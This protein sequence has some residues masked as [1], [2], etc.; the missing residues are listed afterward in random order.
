MEPALNIEEPLLREIQ[1]YWNSRIHDQEIATAPVNS[2][3]FFEELDAY[4]YEKL[5]YLP[6]LL[7]FSTYAGKT[8]LE[9]GCGVGTDLVRFAR[10]GAIVTGVDIAEHSINLAG[11]NFELQELTADLRVMNGEALTFETN[12]FDVVY[13]HGV[14]QYTANPSKMVAEIHRVLKPHGQAI[15]MFYNRISWLN[16]VSKVTKVSLE[17]DDAPAFHLVSAREFRQLLAPFTDVRLIPERFPVESRL[18]GGLK[19]KLYN[20]L[21]V[22]AFHVLPKSV[23]RRFGWHLMAFATK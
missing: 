1:E 6:K 9:I 16:A 21:F 22:P 23:V 3:E 11:R 12:T 2:R 4:R 10:H 15:L 8:V 14:L 7:D 5:D 20:S 19:G 17:H 13:A 18:H